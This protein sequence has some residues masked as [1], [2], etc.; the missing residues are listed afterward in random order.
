[1]K[2]VS[3]LQA[4]PLNKPTLAASYT[5]EEEPV[6]HLM[7]GEPFEMGPPHME[8]HLHLAKNGSLS[9]KSITQV[10]AAIKAAIPTVTIKVVK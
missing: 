7:Q 8:V 1:M 6:T 10:K 4:L 5:V 9:Q 3:K 2:F